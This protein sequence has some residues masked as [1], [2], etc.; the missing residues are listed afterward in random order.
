MVDR[1][2]ASPKW[3]LD[4]RKQEVVTEELVWGIRTVCKQVESLAHHSRWMCCTVLAGHPLSH[5]NAIS[6]CTTWYRMVK[7]KPLTGEEH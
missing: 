3:F 2:M 6:S 5:N 1:L 7:H 4:P